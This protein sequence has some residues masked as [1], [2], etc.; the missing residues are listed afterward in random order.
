MPIPE[1]EPVP[2]CQSYRLQVEGG[3]IGEG[4]DDDGKAR[5]VAR[6]LDCGATPTQSGIVRRAWSGL[7]RG[8]DLH[9]AVMD[10]CGYMKRHAIDRGMTEQKAIDAFKSLE[11]FHLIEAWAAR[12][13]LLGSVTWEDKFLWAVPGYEKRGIA[14]L[15]YA[16]EL[17]EP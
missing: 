1:P 3:K 10:V 12:V 11:P 2:K 15:A 8:E 7:W 17:L 6:C 4:G 13:M 9:A 16:T 14:M 5:I